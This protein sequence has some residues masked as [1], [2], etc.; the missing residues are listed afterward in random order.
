MKSPQMVYRKGSTKIHGYMVDTKVIEAQDYEKYFAEGW[1]STPCDTAN[2]NDKPT[3]AELEEKA[4]ELGIK[5]RSNTRD[6]TISDKIKEAL[7]GL[8]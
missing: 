8:D 2:G 3:R 5:F 1:R 6:S 4:I 7:D